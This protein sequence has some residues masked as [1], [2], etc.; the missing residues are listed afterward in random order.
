MFDTV[1]GH[2]IHH[3]GQYHFE[4][5]R[6]CVR[7]FHRN[8]YATEVFS[9][10]TPP[11]LQPNQ[12]YHVVG[13]Y[14]SRTHLAK[15]FVNGALVGEE[16]GTGLLSL[17]WEAKAGFGSHSGHR[18]L[19]GYLDEIYIFR[20]ALR[21]PEINSYLQNPV[22]NSFVSHVSDDMLHTENPSTEVFGDVKTDS[23]WFSQ[24]SLVRNRTLPYLDEEH[25]ATDSRPGSATPVV[26]STRP[27]PSST[28]PPVAPNTTIPPTRKTTTMTHTTRES[29]TQPTT[30]TTTV[31][32][33]QT[34]TPPTSLKTTNKSR[35]S[36]C[37]FGNVYRNRD[38]VGGLGAG[39]F[40]DK[41]KVKSIEHCMQMC[42]SME[43][44]SVAYM[45]GHNCFAINCKD[46]EQCKT[47]SKSPSEN[48]PVL[49][50]VQRIK[51]DGMRYI[52]F[53]SCLSSRLVKLLL[54][55]TYF[56]C[57]N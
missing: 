8:E 55:I 46:K 12:W 4:V 26:N 18:S 19:L 11:L 6:G 23:V 7:W 34:T 53:F 47:F 21:E 49:G 37:R 38:L 24:P 16:Q 48:S 30:Q 50:I 39:N 54:E 20:R 40:T 10:R 2:S 36:L 15:V 44:C 3:K 57:A 43:E 41:G 29:T 5:E 1:G 22:G 14:D 17:D 32:T 56:P 51:P 33:K 27:K 25:N 28:I 9:V 13:T 45:V 35:K 31:T 52:F 42:C